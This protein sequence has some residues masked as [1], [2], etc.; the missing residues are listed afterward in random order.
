MGNNP[1][2]DQVTTSLEIDSWAAP[3]IEFAGIPLSS[4]LVA[5]VVIFLLSLSLLRQGMEDDQDK[6]HASA[7]I[8]AMSFGTLSLSSISTILTVICAA[9]SIVFAGLV[10]WLSSG[11]LQAI[12]DDRKKSKIGTRAL[13]EDHDKEQ[14]NTRKEL[15]AIISCAPLAFLPFVLI[16]PS[17]AID[18]GASSLISLIG[19]ILLSPLVVHLMLR[20]LDR[21]YDA[22]YSQL[23]E[24]ELRAIRLKKILGGAGTRG[25]GGN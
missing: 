25:S 24:I 23:A 14:A 9:A 7:Y 17:L 13:I 16:S 18:L 20:F 4:A 11:E 6:L 10:A 5:F 15:R 19:F 22:L 3:G 1:D 12:H 2:N 21:S 8:A